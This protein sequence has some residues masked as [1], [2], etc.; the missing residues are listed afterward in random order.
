MVFYIFGLTGGHFIKP[1]EDKRSVC[2][3]V[4]AKACSVYKT[5]NTVLYDI[6]DINAPC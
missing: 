6:Y 5:P 4:G 1:C 2:F 3:K